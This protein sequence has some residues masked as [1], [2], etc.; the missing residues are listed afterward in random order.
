MSYKIKEINDEGILFENGAKI[1][2]K[3]EQDWCE[4]VYASWQEG[5]Q[6]TYFEKQEFDE[7]EI[8]LV[9]NYGIRINGYGVPCYNIQNGYYS[10]ELTIVFQK[11]NGEQILYEVSNYLIDKIED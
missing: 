10:S 4:I 9:K 2:D 8:E 3:H 1:F 11:Q 5:L 7:I 6:D